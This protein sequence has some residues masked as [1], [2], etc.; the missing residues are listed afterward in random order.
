MTEKNKLL[1]CIITINQGKKGNEYFKP[2]AF[3]VIQVIGKDPSNSF[4]VLCDNVFS[5]A[6]VLFEWFINGCQDVVRFCLRYNTEPL[7]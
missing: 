5:T 7:K 3:A 6:I 2:V 1:F 4:P